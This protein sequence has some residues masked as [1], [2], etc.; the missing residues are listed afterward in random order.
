MNRVLIAA[1]LIVPSAAHSEPNALVYQLQERCAKFAADFAK[2]NGGEVTTSNTATNYRA[3]YNARLNKRYY[4][5]RTIV[6]CKAK[7]GHIAR[8][9]RLYDVLEN[10]EVGTL[11]DSTDSSF[12]FCTVSGTGCRSEAE[13]NEFVK[14]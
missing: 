8:V 6:Y 14:P 9:F 2:A 10:R 3:H 7:Q 13:W 4:L 11:S 12:V 1:A 5:D